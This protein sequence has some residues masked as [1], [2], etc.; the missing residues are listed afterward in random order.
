[1]LLG[2]PKSNV[3]SVYILKAY[4]SHFK[5][6]IFVEFGVKGWAKYQKTIPGTACFLSFVRVVPQHLR[7]KTFAIFIHVH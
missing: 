6:L 4:Q 5:P 2:G 7:L 1:M 3:F